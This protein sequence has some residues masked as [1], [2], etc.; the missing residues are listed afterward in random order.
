MHQAVRLANLAA[1]GSSQGRETNASTARNTANPSSKKSA[2]PKP[3]G[4]RRGTRVRKRRSRSIQRL[5]FS[6]RLSDPRLGA[7]GPYFEESGKW[8]CHDANDRAHNDGRHA[9]DQQQR[10]HVSNGHCY[11]KQKAADTQKVTRQR[12]S[13]ASRKLD[14]RCN[15]AA[16][17]QGKAAAQNAPK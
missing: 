15:Q 13:T 2:A 8:Q 12:F 9:E 11:K 17:C 16:T 10:S 3:S 14:G 1:R 5:I 7:T 4:F 6:E